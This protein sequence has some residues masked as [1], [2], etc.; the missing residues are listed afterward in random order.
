MKNKKMILGIAIIVVIGF[1]VI[2]CKRGSG[3]SVGKIINSPEELKEYLNNSRQANS[4]DNPI[5]ISMTIDDSMLN[6]VVEV[7]DSANKYV[8]LNITGNALTN[9]PEIAFFASTKLAG[10]TIPES[11]TSIERLAF[12]ECTRLISVT[13]KGTI[14]SSGLD[15]VSFMGDLREQYL[16]GGIGT[17]T[18]TAPVDYDADWTKKVK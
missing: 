13:F 17:Y 4:P 1:T 12:I 16:N 6:S 11:V 7:I 9:I 14:T 8:S 5:K 2:A 18:T 3:G 15:L 10:I